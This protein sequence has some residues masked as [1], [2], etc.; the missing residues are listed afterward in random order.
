MFDKKDWEQIDKDYFDVIEVSSYHITLKSRP[1][2]HSWDITCRYHP[3]GRSL[4]ILHR[5]KDSDPFHEQIRFH[6][7]TVTQAQDLIKEHDTWVL[8]GKK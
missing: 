5:H 7:S 2:G 8:N 1:T 4:I 6:P 3:G